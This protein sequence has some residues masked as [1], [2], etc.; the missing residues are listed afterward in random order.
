MENSYLYIT[1]YK[2]YILSDPSRRRRRIENGIPYAIWILR[3]SSNIIR[4]N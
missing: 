4:A 1:G 2:K 3:I